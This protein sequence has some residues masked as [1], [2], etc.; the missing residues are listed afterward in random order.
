MFA[1]QRIVLLNSYAMEELP[2][3]LWNPVLKKLDAKSLG[4]IAATNH[5]WWEAS[6]TT[7]EQHAK[8]AIGGCGRNPTRP[9]EDFHRRNLRIYD[10]ALRKSKVD[11]KVVELRESKSDL[12]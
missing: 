7:A 10:A 8:T 1:N 3:D 9:T 11:A 12:D 5:K 4:W 2:N 6:R